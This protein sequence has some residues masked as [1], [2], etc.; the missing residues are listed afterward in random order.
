MDALVFKTFGF[1]LPLTPKT[2]SDVPPSQVIPRTP[3]GTPPSS[4]PPSSTDSLSSPLKF[5]PDTPES[6]QVDYGLSSSENA[7]VSKVFESIDI[8][9]E[10]NS[11]EFPSVTMKVETEP[12]DKATKIDT[13]EN[14]IKDTNQESIIE[15]KDEVEDSKE[16]EDDS[17]T[18]EKKSVKIDT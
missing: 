12:K 15:Q 1:R 18:S 3:S 14:L 7:R 9:K 4:T 2:P 11:E 10:E 5:N 13:I 6:K 17:N 8:N 16:D